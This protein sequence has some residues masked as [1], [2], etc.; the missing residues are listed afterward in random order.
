VVFFHSIVTSKKALY[1]GKV[2]DALSLSLS[3]SLSLLFVG[4]QWRG[5]VPDSSDKE[6]KNFPS[7]LFD[8]IW[9]LAIFIMSFNPSSSL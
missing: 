9:V 4:I 8:L 7:F 3:L 5:R 6:V 2:N 1:F